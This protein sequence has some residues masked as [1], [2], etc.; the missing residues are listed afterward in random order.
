MPSRRALKLACSLERSRTVMT[1]P[2][3]T[4]K[5]GKKFGNDE[6]TVSITDANLDVTTSESATAGEILKTYAAE[7]FFGESKD[8]DQKD[9]TENG[10]YEA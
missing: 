4:E 8:T 10:Q 3:F 7:V 2:T 5:D 6:T 1:W 9:K